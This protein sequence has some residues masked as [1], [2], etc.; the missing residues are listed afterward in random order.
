MNIE[1]EDYSSEGE[2]LS[3]SQS[4]YSP[5]SEE[6]VSSSTSGPSASQVGSL[7]ALH[8]DQYN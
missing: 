5:D 8:L 7:H 3:Q 4:I 1:T 6:A 2:E